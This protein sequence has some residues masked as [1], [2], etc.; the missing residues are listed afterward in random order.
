[1]IKTLTNS[2]FIF[3]FINSLFSQS[4]KVSKELRP[5]SN[6]YVYQ[7]CIVDGDSILSSIRISNPVYFTHWDSLQ[8]IKVS[9]SEFVIFHQYIESNTLTF[10]KVMVIER[11]VYTDE[12]KITKQSGIQVK[13]PFNHEFR[14][15]ILKENSLLL[16]D[17]TGN[18]I[19]IFILS[20]Y[21]KLED[22]EIDW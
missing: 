20:N 21:A 5:F 3:F 15:Y 18:L 17:E 22:L 4:F 6:N 16:F 13:K 12:N 14:R 11:Y 9:D 8:F 1:M 7:V 2:A 10:D 19:K